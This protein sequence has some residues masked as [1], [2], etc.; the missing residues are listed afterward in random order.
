MGRKPLS[1]QAK[2]P[3]LSGAQRRKLRYEAEEKAAA[4]ATPRTPLKPG[5]A[6]IGA[7]PSTGPSPSVATSAPPLPKRGRKNKCDASAETSTPTAASPPPAEDEAWA[8]EFV[9]RAGKSDL[10]NPD[11]DLAYV[12]KL[13]LIVLDQ[14]AATPH[15]S[16]RSRT[17]GGASAR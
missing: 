1:P 7:P 8:R 13:Q 2:K 16:K 11:T 12:R 3:R 6:K 9:E 10:A 5:G 14:M 15:P 17:R 4:A